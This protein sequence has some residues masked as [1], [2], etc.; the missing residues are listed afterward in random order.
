MIEHILITMVKEECY[1]R[2]LDVPFRLAKDDTLF[3]FIKISSVRVTTPADD[4]WVLECE[5]SKQDEYSAEDSEFLMDL[6]RVGFK[7]LKEYL[8]A[9]KD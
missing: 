5:I 2:R 4:Y 7:P 9:R 6:S 8:K 1:C 3:G